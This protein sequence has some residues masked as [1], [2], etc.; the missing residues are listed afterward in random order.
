M[1][2]RFGHLN[3]VKPLCLTESRYLLNIALRIQNL[4]LERILSSG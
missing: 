4:V 3:A 1:H 2:E